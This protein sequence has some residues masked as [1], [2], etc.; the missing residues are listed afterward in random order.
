MSAVAA[1]PSVSSARAPAL[2]RRLTC[3][4]YEGVLLFGVVFIAAYLFSTLT[5]Q[6]NGLTHHLWLMGWLGVVVGVYFVWF[7]THGGQTLPMKTW[8]FRIVDATLAPIGV[9]RAIARYVLSWLWWLPPLAAH[10]LLGLS[11]P[12]TLAVLIGWIALWSAATLLDTDRQFLH[13][14]LAGTRIVSVPK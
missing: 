8:R 5:Q 2:R 7:W 6:R 3:L 10:P 12:A 4:V 11:V 14:R 13:D 9:P 1:S